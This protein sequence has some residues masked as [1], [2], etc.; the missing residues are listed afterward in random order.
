MVK[1]GSNKACNLGQLRDAGFNVPPFF[2]VR[3]SDLLSAAARGPEGFEQLATDLRHEH[4]AFFHAHPKVAVR[5]SASD[6]DQEG[7]AMAGL[8]RS[9]LNVSQDSLAVSLAY[10]LDARNSDSLTAYRAYQREEHSGSASSDSEARVELDLIVQAMVVEQTHAAILFTANPDGLLNERVLAVAE[11]LGDKLVSDQVPSMTYYRHA[12]EAKG[13]LENPASLDPLPTVVTDRIWSLAK[14]IEAA[15]GP[16]LDLELAIDVKQEIHLLQMRPLGH[17]SQLDAS[18]PQTIL[19]NSNIIE[20][21]PGLT[22]PLSTDFYKR[23]YEAVFGGLIRRLYP[24]PGAELAAELDEITR[25][26]VASWNGR[27]YYQLQNWLNLLRQ[28]P[29]SN[30]LIPVWRE[31][32]G[33]EAIRMPEHK[34]LISRLAKPAMLLRLAASILRTERYYQALT[35]AVDTVEAEFSR[36][37]SQAFVPELYEIFFTR[38]GDTVLLHWDI[39]LLNDLEAMVRSK[40]LQKQ[41]SR[42]GSEDP[43]ELLAGISA[44]ASMKPVRS[45]RAIRNL[46]RDEDMAAVSR[47]AEDE[48]FARQILR[49]GLPGFGG[50]SAA[51]L[52]SMMDTH[53]RLYGDRGIEELKLERH[54]QRSDPR[55]FFLALLGLERTAEEPATESSDPAAAIP[56]ALPAQFGEPKSKALRA[57]MRRE[58]SRLLRTRVYGMARCLFLRLGLALHERGRLD[59]TEDVFYLLIDEVFSAFHDETDLRVL[60]E[61]RK[62]SY[63]AYRDLP[64]Y[65][66][67][68]FRAEPFSKHSADYTPLES[69]EELRDHWQGTPCS[70][71]IV[72]AEV[73]VV[74]DAASVTDVSGRILVTKQTDPGWVYLLI[75]AGGVI[76]ERGSILSHTAIISRELGIPSIVGVTGIASELRTGDRILMDGSTGRINRLERVEQ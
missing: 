8:Y 44:I 76:A 4:E 12:T 19:D 61:E 54:T 59:G 75:Q 26:M 23:A 21:Y 70:A 25:N 60:V 1:Q 66:R 56:N 45:I 28:L 65:S 3:S 17:L 46:L 11:G 37:E 34:P 30:R 49:G 52:L 16:A 27:A 38:L 68:F 15:F 18:R 2:V 74:E 33:I 58:E 31:M 64:A 6:E 36:L 22:L 5:S 13:Y 14:E 7:G 29:L 35:D 72:Q 47:A 73:L 53:I 20:S 39:T 69:N 9:K 62:R 32:L 50:E 41:A 42:A 57:I 71:G 40:Q 51:T 48:A 63:R 24:K 55:L 10:C 43:N 67:L